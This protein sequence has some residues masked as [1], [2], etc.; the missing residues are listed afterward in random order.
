MV[1]V[2]LKTGAERVAEARETD[3]D[4]SPNTPWADQY[5]VEF[6]RG[7]DVVSLRHHLAA[8]PGLTNPRVERTSFWHDK[9]DITIL[10]CPANDNN[11]H[12][13]NGRGQVTDAE[14]RLIEAK[15]RSMPGIKKIYF[16]SPQHRRKVLSR[17]ERCPRLRPN[18]IGSAYHLKLEP[19]M[20]ADNY[21]K[22]LRDLPAVFY[23]FDTHK[24]AV[25]DTNQVERKRDC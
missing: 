23:V 9:A 20:S 4:M 2:R 19:G 25:S 8:I 13:C 10:V 5:V 17:M 21:W 11:T 12:R 3:P 7:A 1:N 14:R 22:D 15:L 6:G 24:I 16:E 18:L